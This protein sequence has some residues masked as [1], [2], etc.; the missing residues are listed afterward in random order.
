MI[1]LLLLPS[2]VRFRTYAR[3]GSWF[4]I[5]TI[6]HN[7]WGP[8]YASEPLWSDWRHKAG[9]ERAALSNPGLVVS[10]MPLAIS[11]AKQEAG[12]ALAPRCL[13]QSDIESGALVSPSNISLPMKK[14]YVCVFPNARAEI[15]SVRLLL[16][17]L[18][19][20]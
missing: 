20:K 6:I 8:S 13:V 19:L 14:D 3:L 1:S 2:L 7:K 16:E 17:F 10:D 4:L 12:V 18:D 11:A 9:Y 15:A 5:L